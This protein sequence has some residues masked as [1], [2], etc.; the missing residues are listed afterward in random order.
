[1]H[2]PHHP[3]IY[4]SS[5][6]RSPVSVRRLKVWLGEQRLVLISTHTHFYHVFC[7]R[8]YKNFKPSKIRS[9]DCTPTPC[10]TPPAWELHSKSASGLLVPD[11]RTLF[12]SVRNS[13]V[14]EVTIRYGGRAGWAGW[15]L[16]LTFHS[17]THAPAHSGVWSL[18]ILVGAHLLALAHLSVAASSWLKSQVVGV[19]FVRNK[20]ATRTVSGPW[21]PQKVTSLYQKTDIFLTMGLSEK[22]DS[23]MV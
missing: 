10:F 23:K 16:A 15:A 8:Q 18:W 13:D 9:G 3:S 5:R 11:L 14:C 19:G 17:P 6:P 21:W 22:K 2:Y 1:M 20:H 7:E 12:H 4:P